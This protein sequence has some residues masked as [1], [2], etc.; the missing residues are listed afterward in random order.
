MLYSNFNQRVW[1][2]PQS[3]LK[4][5]SPTSFRLQTIPYRFLDASMQ[6]ELLGDDSVVLKVSEFILEH[7]VIDYHNM[8]SPHDKEYTI[9]HLGDLL[10][11]SL[12]E[13]IVDKVLE[14]WSPSQ[15]FMSTLVTTVE[16][17]VDPRFSDTTW[18][19]KTCQAKGLDRQRN[20]P[21][22][23]SKD[24]DLMFKL[25]FMDELIMQCPVSEKDEE[26]GRVILEGYGIQEMTGMPEVG[27]IGSQPILFVLGARHLAQRVKHFQR[28]E[29]EKARK[30]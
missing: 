8:V 14:L 17:M 21:F 11:P 2:T 29:E 6:N 30:K 16:L 15:T 26:L 27:G 3:E 20:C 9:K 1:F 5:D 23:D 19:C 7:C 4:S 18:H 12:I 13:E 28:I 24:H 10:P 25:P 22:L